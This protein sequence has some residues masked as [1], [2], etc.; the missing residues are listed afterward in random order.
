MFYSTELRSEV[1][2][3]I[4]KRARDTTPTDKS[5]KTTKEI[6]KQREKRMSL[7]THSTVTADMSHD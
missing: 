1:C 5:L 3:Y 4:K 2:P 7:S 6:G